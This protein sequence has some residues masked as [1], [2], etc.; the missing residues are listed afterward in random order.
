MTSVGRIGISALIPNEKRVR[1][2]LDYG[3]EVLPEEEKLPVI[4]YQKYSVL[5]ARELLD[6]A[7]ANRWT[8]PRWC[9]SSISGHAA[10]R[11]P[12][13]TLS[14]RGVRA[15]ATVVTQK[16]LTYLIVSTLIK[17]L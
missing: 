15:A 13:F 1:V 6:A 5:M 10:R 14:C 2:A 11:C 8:G 12:S 7:D 3:I 17:E 9:I 16:D 4:A